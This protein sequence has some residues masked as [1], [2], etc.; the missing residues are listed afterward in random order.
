MQPDEE[1][2]VFPVT[3][4]TQCNHCNFCQKT[5]PIWTKNGQKENATDNGKKPLDVYAAWNLDSEIRQESSSGGVFSALAEYILS[6]DGV[7]VG[8]AFDEQLVVHHII[9]ED[10]SQLNRL[11][12]S[13]YVQ[14]EISSRLYKSIRSYLQ[15][16]RTVLFSGTP[17]QIAGLHGYL[18]KEYNNLFC[19]DIICH[20]VPSPLFFNEYIT[21][22]QRNGRRILNIKFREK[23]VGWKDF[24]VKQVFQ[25]GTEI[26]NECKKMFL[27]PYMAGFLRDYCLRESCYRCAFA[28]VSREGDLTIADFWGVGQKYPEYD[29]D[30]KGTSLVLVNTLKG[31]TWLEEI[32]EKM[33]IGQADLNTA[34]INNGMLEKAT[35]RPLE[36]NAFYSD[37]KKVSFKKLINKYELCGPNIFHRVK[38]K[39]IHI[40]QIIYRC[41]QSKNRR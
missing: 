10:P 27:D 6:K 33:F 26:Q 11:R 29:K 24:R 40:K 4:I 19:C 31:K 15:K 39:V 17:C 3:D 12:G 18:H 41:I 28:S 36:R 8:A 16:G 14:S 38:F 22:S 1:G 32:R 13:K 2:F 5:C 35:R 23:L 30:D 21:Y 34:R 37:L 25:N 7:V 9:I 20:G